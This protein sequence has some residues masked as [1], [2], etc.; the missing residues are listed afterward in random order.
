MFISNTQNEIIV[1][2][3]CRQGSMFVGKVDRLCC[4]GEVLVLFR[5]L[6]DAIN[7]NLISEAERITLLIDHLGFVAQWPNHPGSQP[8][9]RLQI[10]N[11]NDIAFEVADPP[12]AEAR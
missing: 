5:Q 6:E 4:S 9:S 3:V 8:V 11:G 10:M 12:K 1:S 2:D 7:D